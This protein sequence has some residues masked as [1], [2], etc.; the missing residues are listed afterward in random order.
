M[1]YINGKWLDREERQERIDLLIESVRRL[2]ALIKAKKATD[3]HI[4][5]FRKNKA[6][7]IKLKRVHRAEVDIA[8]FTYEYLS[9]GLNPENEDNVVRNSDDGTPHDGI[10]DIAKIHEEFFE[11]CDYVNEE[12]R[13]ARLAIAAARGHS[14]SGMFSNA[15]PLHQ[16]AYRK[17][18]YILVISETDSLS[19]KLIG[20]VN[21]QMKFNA[22]LREDFGP[23]MHESAS[24]NEKD[25]EEAFITTTNILI[26]SSSSGKQLRGTPL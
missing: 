25:N 9:D 14:K 10:E 26:E 13:N 17:R 15:L 8:Y 12:K 2:A 24:H 20:W 16:A 11:L 7:L 6:E 5:M 1:A 22:K 19:K 21:K 3:Y 23:M 18:K 4:D